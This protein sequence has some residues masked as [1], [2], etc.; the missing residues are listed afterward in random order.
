M[1]ALEMIDPQHEDSFPFELTRIVE[2][3]Y[4]EIKTSKHRVDNKYLIKMYGKKITDLIYDRFQL[5]MV[6]DETLSELMPA[7]IIP[8]SGDYLNNHH[9]KA[10]GFS[11]VK[12]IGDLFGIS[13]FTHIR[14]IVAEKEKQQRAI[15]KERGYIDLKHARVGGYMRKVRHYLIV[16]FMVLHQLDLTVGEV[17]AVILHEIGHA[18]VGLEVH[19][20]LDR[21]N[22][23]IM[24]AIGAINQNDPK[25]LEYIY[26]RYFGEKE[27]VKE[28]LSRDSAVTDFYGPL[29]AKYLESLQSQF[30]NGKYQETEFERQADAFAARFGLEKELVTG[31]HKIHIQHG[32]VMEDNLVTWGVLQVCEVLFFA[33]VILSMGVAGLVFSYL[34]IVALISK[35]A[36][37]M[38]YDTPVDRYDRIR[39]SIVMKLKDKRLPKEYRVELIEQHEVIDEIIGNTSNLKLLSGIVSDYIDPRSIHMNKYIKAQR[40]IENGLSNSLFVKTAQLELL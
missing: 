1:Y 39:H 22:S 23:A 37:T 21:N 5:T 26:R 7:A 20:K 29:A 12:S 34:F 3:I 8:F 33:I 14:K 30:G 4:A 10:S 27:L 36:S 11:P 25:K 17:V 6:L 24:E 31:L 18:F 19:Y 9:Q 13:V 28:G 15:D 2:K 16:N 35:S 32:S 40:A 38:T